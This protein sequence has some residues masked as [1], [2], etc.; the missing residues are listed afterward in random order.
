MKSLAG[1]AANT[2]PLAV[3]FSPCVATARSAVL[4]ALAML[5]RAFSTMLARPPRLLPGVVFREDDGGAGAD[6]QVGGVTH[7]RIAGDPGECV[8]A[9]ALQS[10]HQ[11][12]RG[13]GPPAAAVEFDQPLLRRIHNSR[14]HLRETAEVLK[15]DH[16]G[17]AQEW[18][19]APEQP[20]G[21]QLFAAERDHQ[22]LARQV[23]V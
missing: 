8:A 4:P 21:W 1:V 6:Q 3:T 20:R 5:P 2:K 15:A 12:G 9:A 22:S 14:D 18:K 7:G 19:T 17:L 10:D 11:A 16:V 23:G 13:A